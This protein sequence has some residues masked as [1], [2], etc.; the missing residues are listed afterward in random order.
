MWV[1]YLSA[2]QEIA[3][4]VNHIFRDITT[5]RIFCYHEKG[6]SPRML[7]DFG[8]DAE[9]CIGVFNLICGALE[10]GKNYFNIEA[11]IKKHIAHPKGQ[12]VRVC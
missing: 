5:N 12:G 9:S 2:N 7:K 6:E 3:K 8:E 4:K 11:G 10:D 1:V